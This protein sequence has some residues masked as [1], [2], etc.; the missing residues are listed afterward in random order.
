M[1]S[2]V[3]RNKISAEAANAIFSLLFYNHNTKKKV[4][5]YVYP[6]WAIFP[7][8]RYERCKDLKS[9]EEVKKQSAPMELM[10]FY[11]SFQV[12]HAKQENDHNYLTT[13]IIKT[14]RNACVG[15]E[16]SKLCYKPLRKLGGEERGF[17]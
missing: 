10:E 15:K 4:Y 16:G 11:E 7:D 13:G 9:T 17:R 14:L 3:G 2:F 8:I 6:I 1:N 5:D 12:D